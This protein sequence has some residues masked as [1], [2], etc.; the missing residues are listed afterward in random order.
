MAK[1]K[2]AR[3]DQVALIISRMAMAV[4][5]AVTVSLPLG[6]AI[7]A[8]DNAKDS[9]EFKAKVK[10]SALNGLIANAPDVWMFAENRIQGLISRE[11]VPLTNELVQ[12]FDAQGKL[13]LESGTSPPTP[14]LSRSYA[15]TDAGQVVGRIAVTGSQR[16]LALNTLVATLVGLALGLLVF[17]VMRIL[18]L[19]ALRKITDALTEERDRVKAMLHAIGDGVITTD[20]GGIVRHLNQAALAIFDA[21]SQKQLVGH[22]VV[23][24]IAP[25]CR[26]AYTE[27]LKLVLGGQS[28]QHQY[29]VIGFNGR[30]RWLETSAVSLQD[31]GRTVHLSVARDI[32]E[33][34]K[35]DAELERHRHQLEEIVQERTADLRIAAAAFDSQE[36]MMVTDANR[37]ILQVNRAF[38]HITGYAADEV[39][40]QEPDLL[41]SGRHTSHFYDAMWDGAKHAG[42]WQGEVWDRRKNGEVYPKWMTLSALK[43]EDG[44]TTHYI[45]AHHDITARKVAEEEIRHL[46]FYDHLTSLPNRRLLLDRLDQAM[47]SSD[48]SKQYAA[49]MFIDLDHFKTLNDTLG[50]DIGDLLLQQVAKRLESC[51]REGDTVARL[52]GDEFVVMIEGLSHDAPEA[53]RQTELVGNTI[54]ATLN[55]PY[56]LAQ[57]K[58]KSTPS[59]GVTLFNENMDTLGDLMKQADLAMYKAK[60]GG[61]NAICFFDTEMQQAVTNRSALESAL[62]A[63]IEQENLVLHYQAQVDVHG[64]L[65]GVEAL[66]RWQH[67][68]RGL[69]SPLEFIPLAEETDLIIPLGRWVLK[70]ACTQL[71]MWANQ[72]ALSH[73]TMSV[74]VSAGQFHQKYF[75]DEVMAVIE[76]TGVDPRRLKLELTESLLVKD[77]EDII[78]KMLLLKEKGVRFSLDDFGTGYSSLSHLK[79]L[80]LYQLKIDKCFVTNILTDANDAAIAKMV[81]VLA[82]SLRLNVIAEGVETAAQ[83]DFLADLGC[84]GYQGYLFSQPLP[85]DAFEEFSQSHLQ[86]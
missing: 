55:Q 31:Q 73:L 81:L 6:Y 76:G 29:E 40:G 19:R 23:D 3:D 86:S 80:P 17:V 27:H 14:A 35:T 72:V 53:T 54:L 28:L 25:E 5:L 34:K 26:E 42:A 50:H 12:I 56:Q 65:T 24:V 62:R 58:Y 41:K 4:A 1:L 82:E 59:I 36:A 8:L 39:V 46:A 45:S 67:P 64:N 63:A 77:V 16:Q 49:L 79:R 74:N 61:R 7:T 83:K 32:T 71:A 37:V 38:T 10:A 11:P 33:R 15:L 44:I 57:H 60:V 9:L 68:Q 2:V 85:A 75:V 70:A 66:V 13:L 18:P 84:H 22:A 52:G 78:A 69:V 47:T 43:N 30:R 48:R 20:A 21:D 51:T